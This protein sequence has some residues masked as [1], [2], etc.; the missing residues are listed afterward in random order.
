MS[1]VTLI[2][3][4]G[5]VGSA[6]LNEAL[7]RGIEVTAVVRNPEKIQ[8]QDDKLTVVQADVFDAQKL[9]EIL[10]GS[11]AVLSAY[12]PGWTNPNIVEDTIKGNKSIIEAVKKA[13]LKRL[14]A[15]GGAGTLNVA[16]GKTVIEAG[17]IPKEILAGVE[18]YA[19]VFYE[20]FK[21]EKDLDWAFFS[22]AGLIEPG[23][24]TANYKLGKDDLIVDAEGKSSISVQDYAKAFIDEYQQP[25]HHQERFTIGY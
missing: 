13:N 21:P 17:F 23:Q 18:A 8:I 10:V 25:Q 6:L 16:P 22:P 12:S 1:K 24:R 15:V 7:S 5:F 20:D 11:D 2:G 9:S 4:S 19:K 14:I 3:A